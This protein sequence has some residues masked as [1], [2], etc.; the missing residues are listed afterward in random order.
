ME[1]VFA[2]EFGRI[3]NFP[4]LKAC[5]MKAGFY[6]EPKAEEWIKLPPSS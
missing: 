2:D 1:L 4:G 3:F 5:G 6:F